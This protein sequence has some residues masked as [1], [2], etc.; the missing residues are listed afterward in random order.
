MTAVGKIFK[1]ALRHRAIE[2]VFASELEAVS[3]LVASI[4]V[5]VEEDK[6]YGTTARVTAEPAAGADPAELRRRIDSVLGHYTV[7]YLVS[8]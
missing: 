1:P 5:R 4:D 6:T 8:V 7:R 3:E 2:E